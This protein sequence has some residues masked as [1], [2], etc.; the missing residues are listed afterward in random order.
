MN[1]YLVSSQNIFS[2]DYLF[3]DDKF[4]VYKS[5][6]KDIEAYLSELGEEMPFIAMAHNCMEVMSKEIR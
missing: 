1:T 6:K 3:Q 4:R 5:A 2:H